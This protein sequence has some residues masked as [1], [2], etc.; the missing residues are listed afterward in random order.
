M[1]APDGWLMPRSSGACDFRGARFS[2][3][4]LEELLSE[5]ARTVHGEGPD[6]VFDHLYI[7]RRMTPLNLF[8]RRRH[9]A[10]RRRRSWTTGSA[11]ATSPTR[12][13]SRATC[14]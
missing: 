3:E 1:T 14:Y 7:E 11:S 6:L 10:G 12:T 13:S 2:A 4:L 5:T 9:R 8:L